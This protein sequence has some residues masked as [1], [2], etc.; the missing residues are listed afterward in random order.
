MNTSSWIK[1]AMA[2]LALLPVLA[3]AAT[4]G[5]LTI[6]DGEVSVLRDSRR[7]VAAEGLRLRSDD[8]VRTG[9]ATQVVRVELDD[10][11]ALD[12]GP[13]TQL[14]LRPRTDA[15]RSAAPYLLQGWAKLSMPAKSTLAA[16]L[17]TPRLEAS[18][19][20]GI[21]VVRVAADM[22]WLF[23]E[24]GSARATPR[25]P[26]PDGGEQLLTEGSSWTQRGNEPGQVSRHAPPPELRAQMPRAFADSLPRRAARFA[27]VDTAPAAA[28]E[29]GY[30]EV[31]P[32]LNAEASL[33]GG[34]V[35][36]YASLARQPKARAALVA[37]LKLH[38]E[39]RKLLFPDP[40][41]PKAPVVAVRRAPTA[42]FAVT[43]TPIPAK[44]VEVPVVDIAPSAA[45]VPVT[46]DDAMSTAA[47]DANTST[48]R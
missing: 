41:R 20:A 45:I 43:T 16:S 9:T 42:T 29:V 35:Q 38:P 24:A 46:T 14:L 40:P 4:V 7:F 2:L 37:D 47:A 8:I 18:G 31:A 30:D 34:F 3:G 23:V 33:R 12:L 25:G 28:A 1:S 36:R 21:A 19:I 27:D 17:S 13:A 11:T 6:A 5:V 15:G 48:A 26:A 10:G 44:P 32:W 39:W 22:A